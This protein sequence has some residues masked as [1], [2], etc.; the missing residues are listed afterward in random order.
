MILSLAGRLV[1]KGHEQIIR[2]VYDGRI[3]VLSQASDQGGEGG[4]LCAS[5]QVHEG[6][7]QEV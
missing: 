6:H 7:P 1:C 3:V 5:R 2:D 4:N